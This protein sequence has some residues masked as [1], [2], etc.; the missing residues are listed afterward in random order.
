MHDCWKDVACFNDIYIYLKILKNQETSNNM[1][2]KVKFKTYFQLK[3]IS[4]IYPGGY[5]T[6]A[7][8]YNTELVSLLRDSVVS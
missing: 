2:V 6:R 8:R 3:F 1:N 4:T 5:I 7:W